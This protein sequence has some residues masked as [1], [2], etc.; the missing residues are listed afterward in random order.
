MSDKAKAPALSPETWTAFVDRAARDPHFDTGKFQILL[1]EQREERREME[2]RAYNH[3]MANAQEQ[4]QLVLRDKPNTFLKSYY[5]SHR[6]LYEMAHPKYTEAGFSLSYGTAEPPHQGW[7]RVTLEIAH[8]EG[9]EKRLFLD[10]PL[11]T[12]GSQGGRTAMTP[13]QAVGATI[14]YLRK[15][16][17]MMAFNLVPDEASLPPE[18]RL[19]DDG[20][21]QRQA[22]G[23]RRVVY[24]P[25]EETREEEQAE[26]LDTPPPPP[27]TRK[28][29]STQTYEQWLQAELDRQPTIELKRSFL[30]SEMARMD[31]Q[32]FTAFQADQDRWLGLQFPPDADVY[33]EAIAE[34]AASR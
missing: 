24:P 8:R 11:H 21:H 6:A 31:E 27:R 14:T 34:Y 32:T 20:E 5:T 18:Q 16:L 10:S 1:Q 30:I 4:M 7:I 17:L 22:R 23:S 15:Y 3:A 12:T 19:D 9:H 25:N 28:G 33:R 26:L 29:R 13:V 2:R